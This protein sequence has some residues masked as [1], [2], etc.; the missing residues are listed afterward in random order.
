MTTSEPRFNNWLFRARRRNTRR[1][2]VTRCG[3]Y[4]YV[5]ELISQREETKKMLSN[6]LGRSRIYVQ[7]TSVRTTRTFE[8]DGIHFSIERPVVPDTVCFTNRKPV[9]RKFSA[10]VS[11]LLPFC[12]ARGLGPGTTTCPPITI[13]YPGRSF[14]VRLMYRFWDTTPGPWYVPWTAHRVSRVFACPHDIVWVPTRT[15]LGSARIRKRFLGPL[16]ARDSALVRV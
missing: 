8:T 4:M 14:S 6:N 9:D 15:R 12:A 16:E 5:I 7:Y 1:N 10:T 13:H 11:F 3:V 2:N